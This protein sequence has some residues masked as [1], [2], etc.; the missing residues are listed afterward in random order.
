MADVPDTIVLKRHRD[1]EGRRGGIWWRRGIVALLAAFL[2]AGLLDVF[3]QRPGGT[4]VDSRAASLELYAPAH[5]RGGL[6][7]EARFTIEAHR[8]LKHAVLLLAPGWAE[9]Q[10]M[11][12]IEP[13]PVSQTSSDG[14][15]SLLLGH[16]DAGSTYRL[17]IEFQVNPT[18]IGRRSQDVSLYDGNRRLVHIARVATFFP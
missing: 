12:T 5:L 13:S 4:T 6:L 8:P 15:L 3:G 7:Y 10:Q 14:Q 2:V 11:N 18:N 9:S 1:L 16:I 17:F